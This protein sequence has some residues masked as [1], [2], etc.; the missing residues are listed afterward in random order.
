MSYVR[1][2]PSA[3]RLCGPD[4]ERR[5]GAGP[6][7]ERPRRRGRQ[8]HLR[9]E[10]RPLA[11]PATTWSAGDR[12]RRCS[13]ATFNVGNVTSIPVTAPAGGVFFVRV[14]ASARRPTPRTRCQVVVTSLVTPP[15]TPVGL[16]AFR[17]GTG[18]LISWQPGGGGPAAGYILRVGTTPGRFGAR[19]D[20]D[21][22]HRSGGR[23]RRPG[24]HLLPRASRRSTPAARAP[25]RRP[26]WSCRPAAPATRRPPR[27]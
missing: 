24:G 27:P 13:L 10:R 17:N 8:R 9:V 14:V 2:W 6:R 26:C 11:R 22:R 19:R 21:R 4:G 5:P 7:H 12:P 23:W 3:S 18:V 25:R 1:S 20:P 15:A 16:Q